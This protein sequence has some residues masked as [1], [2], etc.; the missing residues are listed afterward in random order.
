MAKKKVEQVIG[1]WEEA[2]A[3][4]REL[5]RI[6][7]ANA[8]A[9]AEAHRETSAIMERLQEATK[10]GADRAKTI[11]VVLEQFAAKRRDELD[12]K[13]KTLTSGTVGFRLTPPA[14][15]TSKGATWDDV[16]NALIRLK[17]EAL[18]IFTAPKPDKD[19]IKKLADEDPKLFAKLPVEIA[20]KDEFFAEPLIV[21][22]VHADMAAN[23]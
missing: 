23:S 9:T 13:S 6:E 11:V 10:P 17:R 14:L 4:L 18:L 20:Q 1:S 5:G 16:T 8:A 7:Q 3:L 19:A 12:G 21:T 15:K 2:D 22:P